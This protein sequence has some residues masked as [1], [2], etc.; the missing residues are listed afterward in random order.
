MFAI[1]TLYEVLL[2]LVERVKTLRLARAWSGKDKEDSLV[3]FLLKSPLRGS[4]LD[5]ERDKYTGR[6]H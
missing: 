5:I 6:D 1:K 4:K 2:E 3:E